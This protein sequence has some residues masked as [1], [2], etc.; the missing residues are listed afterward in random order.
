MYTV[1]FN[2]ISPQLAD[3]LIP[4]PGFLRLQE[5]VDGQQ[6]RVLRGISRTLRFV[7]LMLFCAF[8]LY[9]LAAQ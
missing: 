6:T 5:V 1:V 2:E 9:P 7:Y 3:R 4:T 8:L